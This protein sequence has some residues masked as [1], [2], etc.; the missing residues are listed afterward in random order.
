MRN[1]HVELDVSGF[2]AEDI[3]IR[4]N[5]NV[6]KVFASHSKVKD[7]KQTSSVRRTESASSLSREVLL[8][9]EVRSQN[10]KCWINDYGWLVVEGPLGRDIQPTK[11]DRKVTF[12]L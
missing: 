12:Q 8:P 4:T 1:V 9:D 3:H 2:N 11:Q 6:L 7:E 5:G 10:L